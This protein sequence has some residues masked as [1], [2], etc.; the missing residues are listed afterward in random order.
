MVVAIRSAR[1][2]SKRMRSGRRWISESWVMSRSTRSLTYASKNFSRRLGRPLRCLRVPTRESSL[3]VVRL[4]VRLEQRERPVCEDRIDELLD[5]TLEF[6]LRERPQFNGLR[7]TDQRIGKIS[8]T[9]QTSRPGQEELTGSILVINSSLDRQDQF[10]GALHFIDHQ[11]RITS[12]EGLRVLPRCSEVV[13]SVQST[14]LG[15]S[16]ITNR[17]VEA[18]DQDRRR[19]K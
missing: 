1:R 19:S 13:W 15:T 14:K 11:Q 12:N 5:A 2:A 3:E 4:R 9:K 18:T 17:A 16:S 10:R 8:K 6:A 7:T